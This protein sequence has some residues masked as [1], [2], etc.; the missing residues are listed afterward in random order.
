VSGLGWALLLMPVLRHWKTPTLGIS[1]VLCV[2]VVTARGRRK[3][4]EITLRGG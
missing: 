3:P 1:F 2:A 4:A